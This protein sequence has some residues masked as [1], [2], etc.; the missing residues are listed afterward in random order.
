MPETPVELRH[1]RFS[2]TLF[3]GYS[4]SAVDDVI[5]EVV[6]SFETVWRERAELADHVELLEKQL[7]DLRTREALLATTLV[8]A[9]K[10][11]ADA[12]EQAKREAEL[13]I[14]EAH[15]EAR[16]ITRTALADRERLF[17]EARRVEALLRSALSMVEEADGPQREE[18][19]EGTEPAAVAWPKR[20]ETREFARANL[21]VAADEEAQAG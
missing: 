21:F 3:R 11:A 6:A 1:V 4:R 5:E 18:S 10:A 19:H 17:A 13:I 8:S 7:E 14:A 20:E 9:E 12:K 2:R 15:S 16:S